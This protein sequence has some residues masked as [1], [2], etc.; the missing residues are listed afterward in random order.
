MIRAGEMALG[1]RGGNRGMNEDAERYT[2]VSTI[3]SGSCSSLHPSAYRR[4]LCPGTNILRGAI[5][6][7]EFRQLFQRIQRVELLLGPD[8]QTLAREFVTRYC[9]QTISGQHPVSLYRPEWL[10]SKVICKAIKCCF[11]LDHWVAILAPSIKLGVG[12]QGRVG[13]VLIVGCGQGLRGS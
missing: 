3:L 1:A 9:A 10:W 7:E 4:F 12:L 2:D 11:H 13:G 5:D 8:Q 6:E